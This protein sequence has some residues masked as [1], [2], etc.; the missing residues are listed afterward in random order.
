[1]TAISNNQL[2]V[3]ILAAKL[4]ES[5]FRKLSRQTS[6]LVVVAKVQQWGIRY[7]PDEDSDRPYLIVDAETGL[8]V[9]KFQSKVAAKLFMMFVARFL[10][11]G[12]LYLKTLLYLLVASFAFS[13]GM[14]G[15][16]AALGF[17]KKEAKDA[18]NAAEG[19]PPPATSET[20]SG[21]PAQ[22]TQKGETGT[23]AS[24]R[25]AGLFDYS[26]K[27]WHAPSWIIEERVDPSFPD[28]P[29]AIIDTKSGAVVKRFTSKSEAASYMKVL[30]PIFKLGRIAVMA[31]VT[32][33]LFA[34][35]FRFGPQFLETGVVKWIVKQVYWVAKMIGKGL[36]F[37]FKGLRY[38][39][40]PLGPAGKESVETGISTLRGK[41]PSG[42]A[43]R[44]YL[45]V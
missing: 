24:F 10:R 31:A 32:G 6:D 40:K 4:E 2:K 34:I 30:V 1:M 39:T 8:T 20:S 17:F 18:K 23:S 3:L 38:T 25:Q 26:V 43:T 12:K 11:Y 29:A 7:R 5:G 19:N 33:A 21:T 36:G 13:V 42:E 41:L 45:G 15:T 16:S 44:K 22:E 9:K 35:A 14:R 27:A 28:L 37:P